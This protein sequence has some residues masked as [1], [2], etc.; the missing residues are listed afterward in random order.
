MG[1]VIVE[2]GGL[3]KV[4]VLAYNVGVVVIVNINVLIILHNFGG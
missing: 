3:F 2:P 1:V 4:T